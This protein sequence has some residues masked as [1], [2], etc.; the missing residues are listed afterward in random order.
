FDAQVTALADGGFVVAWQAGD[1]DGNGIVGR[2]FD[3]RGE[4][5]DAREFAISELR[6]GDQAGPALSALAD[7]GFAAA[8]VDTQAD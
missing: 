7:G 5:I 6:Q 4:A 2:R 8:W 1:F 3:A